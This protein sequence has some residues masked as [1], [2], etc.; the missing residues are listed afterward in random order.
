MERFSHSILSLTFTVGT[1]LTTGVASSCT[2][3]SIH[4]K[5]S[6]S[7]GAHGYPDPN[8][9]RNCNVELNALGVP[10]AIELD[11]NGECVPFGQHARAGPGTGLDNINTGYQVAVRQAFPTRRDGEL[12]IQWYALHLGSSQQHAL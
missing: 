7:R 6:L 2:W 3:A 4:H 12:M 8:Y 9:F 10:S 1:S 11:N 5:T